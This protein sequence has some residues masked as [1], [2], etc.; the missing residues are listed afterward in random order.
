MP[1]VWYTIDGRQ[2][3]GKPRKEQGVL[4][5]FPK[6]L[7]YCFMK[8]SRSLYSYA[9]DILEDIGYKGYNIK[10]FVLIIL[11]IL[12]RTPFDSDFKIVHLRIL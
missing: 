9:K 4:D 12:I 6:R 3:T 1:D 10:I 8:R 7:V 11:T 5:S 2:L